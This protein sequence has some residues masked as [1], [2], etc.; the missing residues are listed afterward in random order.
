[1]NVPF[2][3]EILL[4][5]VCLFIY[6]ELCLWECWFPFLVSIVVWTQVLRTVPSFLCQYLL[7][8]T[9][10]HIQNLFNSNALSRQ[11]RKCFLLIHIWCFYYIIPSRNTDLFI[12]I[13]FCISFFWIGMCI[14][15]PLHSMYVASNLGCTCHVFWPVFPW[16]NRT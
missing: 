2:D 9:G 3:R 15:F 6:E 12:H 7:G 5:R 14:F 1:M 16:G 13:V 10:T 4:F 11:A 8:G